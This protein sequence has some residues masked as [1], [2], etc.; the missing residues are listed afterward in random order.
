MRSITNHN[1]WQDLNEYLTTLTTSNKSSLAGTIF[2]NLCKYYLQTAPH[3]KSKLKKV[4]LL[5]L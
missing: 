1:S 5:V 4:W 2:E 3:Y